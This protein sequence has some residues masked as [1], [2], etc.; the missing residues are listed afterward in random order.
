MTE[1]NLRTVVCRIERIRRRRPAAPLSTEESQPDRDDGDF[2]I[3][4]SIDEIVSVA[5]SAVDIV[6][7]LE[8]VHDANLFIFLDLDARNYIRSFRIAHTGF[9]RRV[10]KAKEGYYI[11]LEGES[12]A[13]FI[14]LQPDPTAMIETI[15][16]AQY[17]HQPV[18]LRSSSFCEPTIAVSAVSASHTVC[19]ARV[20]M[21]PDVDVDSLTRV[22]YAEAVEYFNILATFACPA[23]KPD[24]RCVPTFY[25]TMG[26]Q[27]RAHRFCGILSRLKRPVR[28]AKKWA[29]ANLL[30]V[31]PPNMPCC[32]IEFD[33]HVAVALK[34]SD[35]EGFY[36]FDHALFD[37]PAAEE[38]WLSKLVHPM[39]LSEISDAGCYDWEY[40]TELR[41][42]EIEGDTERGLEIARIWQEEMIRCYGPPPY[43]TCYVTSHG[44]IRGCA[45]RETG[46]G[47]AEGRPYQ[48]A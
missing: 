45:D 46:S 19:T 36:I 2:E 47:A 26:C 30:V 24:D 1:V 6:L 15:L 4:L 28:A 3:L 10:T 17:A 33:R 42:M 37:R 32:H 7:T 29:W 12:A 22:S 35:R 44:A 23:V 16:G 25:M 14:P 8:R 43:K 41:R 38:V 5:P 48:P 34:A 11:R 27:A 31:E 39:K 20:R 40:P 21:A 9:V 13:H 18:A